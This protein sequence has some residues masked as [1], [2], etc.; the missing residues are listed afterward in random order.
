MSKDN[1]LRMVVHLNEEPIYDII[2]T[3]SFDGLSKEMIALG[4][5]KKK[6]CC[7]DCNAR[8]CG[9]VNDGMRQV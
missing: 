7:I 6:L 8:I 9:S 2:L 3:D 4:S 5:E 1:E